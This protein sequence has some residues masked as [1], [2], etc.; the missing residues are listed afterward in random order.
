MTTPERQR[1][2]AWL[3]L[4]AYVAVVQLA[5]AWTV[6]TLVRARVDEALLRVGSLVMQYA[7]ASYQQEPRTLLLNGARIG[8]SV[9]VS[10]RPVHEVLDHFERR[11]RQHSG[12]LREQFAEAMTHAGDGAR[13][14]DRDGVWPDPVVR[15]DEATR[16]VVACLDLGEGELSMDE[17]SR[18]AG[19]LLLTGDLAQMGALRFVSVERGDT[20]TVFVTTWSD[21]PID[22]PSMFPTEG[23]APGLDLPDVPRPANAR[24][25]LSARESGQTKAFNAYA[26]SGQPLDETRRA[27]AAQ[28][29][30]A[31]FAVP[32]AGT[33]GS[34]T[35]GYVAQRGDAAVVV[36]FVAPERAETIVTISSLGDATSAVTV[37]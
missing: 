23:D 5:A 36:A 13:E 20:Q 37:R 28:M 21:G 9:G 32:A 11:C 10:E 18:R 34:E 31:G 35:S 8:L 4:L 15:A 3:R 27:F 17:L 33:T 22:T 19:V 1:R 12:N 16:G 30:A 25:V 24:R 29:V 7:G 26:V 2:R 6:V 14:V